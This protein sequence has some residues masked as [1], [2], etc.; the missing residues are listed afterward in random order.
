MVQ[1]G[2]TNKQKKQKL[3]NKKIKLRKLRRAFL[4]EFF[5]TCQGANTHV[6]LSLDSFISQIALL[7]RNLEPIC[8]NLYILE[9]CWDLKNSKQTLKKR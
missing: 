6:L 5:S 3:A 1:R 9:H 7:Q 4:K 2:K 8:S